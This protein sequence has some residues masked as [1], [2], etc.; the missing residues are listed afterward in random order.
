MLNEISFEFKVKFLNTWSYLNF[1]GNAGRNL[2]PTC[3]N[4]CSTGFKLCR[5]DGFKALFVVLRLHMRGEQQYFLNMR[6]SFKKEMDQLIF[7]NLL[8]RLQYSVNL[9]P[10][11]LPTN[12]YSAT[13]QVLPSHNR[14]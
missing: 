4:F 12:G 10:T 11:I 1:I 3:S 13:L 7:L 2:I 5:T 8:S 6:D 14:E 9:R